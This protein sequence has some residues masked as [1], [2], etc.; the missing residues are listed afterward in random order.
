MD[1]RADPLGADQPAADRRGSRCKAPGGA[2]CRTCAQ[3]C[4]WRAWAVSRRIIRLPPNFTIPVRNLPPGRDMFGDVL[5]EAHA[6]KIRVVGRFDFSK[7]P[8]AVFDAHPEWFFRQANGDPV[9]YNGLYSTCI[10][11]GYY[12]VQ[13][14]KI[15]TEALEKYDVDGLFFNMFG[16]QSRDYS[17]HPVGLCHCDVCKRLYREQ[18]HKEIPDSAGRRLPQV[19][20]P[21][22]ARGGRG[23]RQADSREAPAGRV[24]QLHSGIDRRHHVG[25]EHGGGASAA[26][27][28]LLGERQ[29]QSRAQQP[30]GQDVG[31]PEHAV[32]GLRVALCHGAAA[33]DRAAVAGRTWRTAAR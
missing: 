6:R 3:T 26:A 22:V 30:A 21:L 32:C 13:A 4:C 11:G 28:A 7:T 29:C 19:H 14:M 8:K 5:R 15:L 20:V 27:V 17:G 1:A 12:R 10:N 16:N 2:A 9:I 24:L 23:D 31:Q 25:I 33:G 18:F